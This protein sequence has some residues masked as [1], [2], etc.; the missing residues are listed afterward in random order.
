M[1]TGTSLHHLNAPNGDHQ[2]GHPGLLGVQ[3]QVAEDAVIGLGLGFRA[4]SGG[5]TE[6]WGE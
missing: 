2:V 6:S 5:K 4:V 1:G 3:R